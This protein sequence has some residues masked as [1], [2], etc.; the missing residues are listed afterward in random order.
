MAYFSLDIFLVDALL[1]YYYYYFEKSGQ[2][3]GWPV[4]T[5]GFI[6]SKQKYVIV[7]SLMIVQWTWYLCVMTHLSHIGNLYISE[8]YI[9]STY[10]S[11]PPLQASL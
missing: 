8:F 9:V 6:T 10:N 7:V 4:E 3:V 1:H 5:S 2:F 11:S